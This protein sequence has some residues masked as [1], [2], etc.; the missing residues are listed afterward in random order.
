MTRGS[1]RVYLGVA[2]GVGKT[3]AM[4]N[5]GWRRHRR[6]TDV[7]VGWVETHDRSETAEQLRDLEVVPPKVLVYRNQTLLEMDLEAIIQ[8]RPSVVLVDELAHTNVPGSV[9]GK[10][11]QDIEDLLDAGITVISTLNIQHLE[12]L[13]DVVTTITGVP[14]RETVPD[15]FVRASEQVELVDMTPE[16][17]RRRMAHG[18]IYPPE[19]IDIALAN[20]FRVGNLAALR[21]LALLWVA[22][23]VDAR[24]QEYRHSHGIDGPWET[25]ERVLVALTGSANGE[26]LIR[27]AARMAQRVKGDLIAVHI[28]SGDGI[29]QSRPDDLERQRSLVI[30]LGGIYREILGSDIAEA[31]IQV[32]RAENCTQIVLGTSHRSRWARLSAGSVINS[33]IAKSGEALDVH[34]ISPPVRLKP[35]QPSDR[36]PR[37]ERRPNWWGLGWLRRELGVIS[38][39][40]QIVGLLVVVVAI[41]L[42]TL[43]LTSIRGHLPLGTVSLVYLLPVIAGAGIGGVGPGVIGAIGGFLLLNW[44]FSPPTHALAITDPRDII[45]LSIFLVIAGVVIVQV[46]LVARRSF[47]AHRIRSQ[48]AS[49]ARTSSALLNL[50]DP[51][52]DLMEEIYSTFLVDGVA[53]L[54]AVDEGWTPEI[55][56]GPHP[57]SSPK[58][59]TLSIPIGSDLLL[60]LDSARLRA[61]DREMLSIFVTQIAVAVANR[62][63]REQ[64]AEAAA[65][66][67]ANDVRTALLVAVSHDLRTPLASIKVAVTSL[68]PD[69]ATWDLTA[70]RTLLETI[71]AEVDRLNALVFNLLDMSRIQTGALI[72][73][74]QPVAL[75]EIVSAALISLP[76]SDHQLDLEVPE[77]LPQVQAD[78]PLL[79][80]AVANLLANALSVSSQHTPVRVV[81]GHQPDDWMELRIVDRGPGIAAV[82]RSRIFMPFQRLGHQDSDNGVG[83]G[84]AVAKGFIEAMG[85]ELTLDDTAGGGTTMIISLRVAEPRS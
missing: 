10:R 67:K 40:R 56:T 24:I 84:L 23:D 21:E 8:R 55:A 12:S 35:E 75:N 29:L 47:D 74:L 61:E 78:P 72:V 31:L 9:H 66:A 41:P 79:E 18:H 63:L 16:A 53:V 51:L 58:E 19:R 54:R 22:D 65:L 14:Q 27:R 42:V 6:G 4:L 50:S 69:D 17:I 49:M 44:Y 57:P 80:R 83:L 15:T 13:N 64:A 70:A 76:P 5:E 20:Y 7:V 59:A 60:V 62:Q 11:W 2:P 43:G 39:R 28:R 73:R 33:V 37:R 85:G 32:A 71:D 25:R 46:G 48:A 36:V 45:A 26:H 82:D 34:V 1:L 38:W 68:L 52:P 77:T 81:A 30:E 3:Y